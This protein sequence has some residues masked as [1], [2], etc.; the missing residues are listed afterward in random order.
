[1]VNKIAAIII[2]I[3]L[4]V[5]GAFTFIYGVGYAEMIGKTQGTQ[6]GAEGLFG[7]LGSVVIGAYLGTIFMIVGGILSLIGVIVLLVGIFAKGNGET[8]EKT[9]SFASYP[10]SDLEVL[11][12]KNEAKRKTDSDARDKQRRIQNEEHDEAKKK[13]DDADRQRHVEERRNY[14]RRKRKK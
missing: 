7:I 4:I 1:M 6:E 9:V 10:H 11:R 2:G 12:K 3:F 8:L 13:H 14:E 5:L